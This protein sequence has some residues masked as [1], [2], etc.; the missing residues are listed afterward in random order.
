VFPILNMINSVILLIMWRAGAL[1]ESSISD[2]HAPRGQVL[3]AAAMV[4]ILYYLCHVIYELIWIQ[5]LSVCLVYSINF[6]KLI[7]SW[8]FRPLRGD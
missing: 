2:R 3:L 1:D 8:I 6:I 7:E 4:L 5:T